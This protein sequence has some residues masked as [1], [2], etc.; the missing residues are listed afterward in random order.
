MRAR[1]RGSGGS[2]TRWAANATAAPYPDDAAQA[3]AL[4]GRQIASPVRFSDLVERMVAEARRDGELARDV[5]A[6]AAVSM[7]L[8]FTSGLALYGSAAGPD[9]H[10]AA[11]RAFRKLL[12]GSL[13]HHPAGPR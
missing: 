7:I 1:P 10:R 3:R 6:A 13:V 9:A 4:L 5:P 8:S 11:V 12:D 2:M